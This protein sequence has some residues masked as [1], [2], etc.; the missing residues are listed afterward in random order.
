MFFVV[1]ILRYSPAIYKAAEALK[2]MKS[3]NMGFTPCS[4]RILKMSNVKGKMTL[5]RKNAQMKLLDLVLELLKGCPL[6][7]GS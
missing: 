1:F 6:V 4:K 5:K 7:V 3:K 2:S